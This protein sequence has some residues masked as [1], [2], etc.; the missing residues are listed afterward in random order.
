MAETRSKRVVT[1][2]HDRQ[3]FDRGRCWGSLMG[4]PL[5]VELRRRVVDFVEEGHSHLAAAAAFRASTKF[6]N[7]M[8]LLKRHRVAG[9]P[10]AGQRGGMA[11]WLAWRTGPCAGSRKS[12]I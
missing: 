3:A 11:S 10:A 1:D 9:G 5:P 7:D 8:V 4:K 6:A 2:R 12:A